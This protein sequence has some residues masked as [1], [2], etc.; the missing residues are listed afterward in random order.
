MTS[1]HKLRIQTLHE[2]SSGVKSLLAAQSFTNWKCSTVQKIYW[3][4]D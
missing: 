1:K 3:R 2:N 4:I